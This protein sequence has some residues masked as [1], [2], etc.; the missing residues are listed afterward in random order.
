MMGSGV[1]L[2][3]VSRHFPSRHMPESRCSV[4]IISCAAE[5]FKAWLEYMR[6][7]E[8]MQSIMEELYMG[9]VGFDSGRYGPDSPFVKAARKKM[10]SMEN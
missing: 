2:A 3:K 4:N 10:D 5:P 9:N 1:S 8:T 6:K 7:G